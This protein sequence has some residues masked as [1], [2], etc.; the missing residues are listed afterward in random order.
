MQAPA[1]PRGRPIQRSVALAVA[2]RHRVPAAVLAAQ[3]LRHVGQVDE[4]VGILM[5][6]VEPAD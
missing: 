2:L 6:I 3:V 4:L 1:A 5:G